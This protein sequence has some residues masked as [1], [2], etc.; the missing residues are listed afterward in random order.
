MRSLKNSFVHVFFK[1][2]LKIMLLFFKV[3]FLKVAFIACRRNYGAPLNT[4]LSLDVLFAHDI[5]IKSE[6][7]RKS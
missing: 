1:I 6:E 2:A 3:T 7:K 4:F 5:V